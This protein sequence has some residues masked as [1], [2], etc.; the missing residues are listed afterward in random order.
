MTIIVKYCK[1]PYMEISQGVFVMKKILFLLFLAVIMIFSTACSSNKMADLPEGSLLD[2]ADSPDGKY[3][4]ETYLCSVKGEMHI[5]CALV[6]KAT[7]ETRNIFWNNHSDEVEVEWIDAS[8]VKIEGKT[9]N[10]TDK[11]AYYDY[12]EE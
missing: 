2:T 10:I 11:E 8:N 12:R 7:S 4:I 3:S 9:I 1:I 6:E 5:R